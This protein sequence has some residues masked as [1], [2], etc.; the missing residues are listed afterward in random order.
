MIFHMFTCVPEE[1]HHSGHIIATSH[2]LA[3]QNVAEEGKSPCFRE[4]NLGW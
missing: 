3:P 2:D 4:L 1:S